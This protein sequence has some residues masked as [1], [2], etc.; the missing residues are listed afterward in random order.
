M[1]LILLLTIAVLLAPRAGVPRPP[2]GLPIYG[3]VAPFSLV[4]QDGRRV[5]NV[6]LAGRPCIV[7][8]IYTSCST[9]CPVMT[10]TMNALRAALG[11]DSP[12]RTVTVTVDP[13]RD[14]PPELREYA[15]A[16]E[17]GDTIYL[18]GDE[19]QILGLMKS[20]YMAAPKASHIQPEMHSSG[21]VLVDGRGRIRGLYYRRTDV[22]RARLLRD[23]RD[24]AS[25][26]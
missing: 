4:D 5:C 3:T 11:P 7:D 19:Q 14:H 23:A 9:A 13:F 26:S 20:V 12:V 8:F 21:F 18:T 15:A 6:D 25:H 17:T 22:E 24:L 16:H 1:K 2:S 10:S